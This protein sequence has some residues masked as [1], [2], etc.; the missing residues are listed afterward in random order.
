MGTDEQ[1]FYKI[2]QVGLQ[3][4]SRPSSWSIKTPQ[5]LSILDGMSIQAFNAIKL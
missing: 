1:K 3:K 2:N 4:Y 5:V